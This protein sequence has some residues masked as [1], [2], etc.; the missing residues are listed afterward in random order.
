MEISCNIEKSTN[1]WRIFC[2]KI[3][4]KAFLFKISLALKNH[5]SFSNKFPRI[6]RRNLICLQFNNVKHFL[7]SGNEYK[8]LFL[9]KGSKKVSY[10]SNHNH[11]SCFCHCFCLQKWPSIFLTSNIFYWTIWIFSLSRVKENC[12][13]KSVAVLPWKFKISW[14]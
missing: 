3:Y 10:Q 8:L 14:A 5:G 4:V 11:I 7:A 13:L 6:F 2:K 12:L 1:P 9:V